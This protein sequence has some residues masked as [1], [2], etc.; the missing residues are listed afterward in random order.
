MSTQTPAVPGFPTSRLPAVN[1]AQVPQRSPLRYPG[2]KTW[3]VPHVRAWLRHVHPTL[4]VD[5]FCG[6]GVVALT[7]V[8]EGLVERCIMLDLDPDVAAF[9]HAVLR[10]GEALAQRVEA[11]EPTRE[12]VETLM[13]TVPTSILDHG[14]RTLVLNRTRR[15][16]ILAPGAALIRQG[17]KW[18]GPELALISGH[19]GTPHPGHSTLRRAHR[20]CSRGCS[21]IV[22]VLVTRLGTARSPVC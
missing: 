14:F 11:F 1:V 7:A 12:R 9:W 10:E 22:A 13:R 4:L 15:S 16:G 6:G 18:P 20:F 19:I 5:P 8:M 21:C 17:G 3:L 2:G